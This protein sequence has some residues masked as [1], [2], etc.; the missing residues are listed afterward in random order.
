[1]ALRK[2][3]GKQNLNWTDPDFIEEV[4]EKISL[5]DK[6]AESFNDLSKENRVKVAKSL[7]IA[8]TGLNRT[9]NIENLVSFL[10]LG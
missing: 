2:G 5:I 1:M 9:K 8:T 3:K 7:G 10:I 6:N 4:V